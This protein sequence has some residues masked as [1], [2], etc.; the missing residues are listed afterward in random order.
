MFAVRS[1]LLCR[2]AKISRWC[3]LVT[4]SA[5]AESTSR[6]SSSSTQTSNM[7]LQPNTTRS[8]STEGEHLRDVL[9][10]SMQQHAVA[11]PDTG[12]VQNGMIEK[13]ALRTLEAKWDLETYQRLHP[14][15]QCNLR[16]KQQRLELIMAQLPKMVNYLKDSRPQ[17]WWQ[18][19]E[20]MELRRT[21]AKEALTELADRMTKQNS[22]MVRLKD[23][24]RDAFFELEIHL[25]FNPAKTGR[26]CTLVNI[27]DDLAAVD[28][29]LLDAFEEDCLNFRTQQRSYNL[30]SFTSEDMQAQK[31]NDLVKALAEMKYRRAKMQQ[32][33]QTTSQK[34][35]LE[36]L[37]AEIKDLVEE[38]SLL[39]VPFDGEEFVFAKDKGVDVAW[40]DPDERNSDGES[41]Q[42]EPDSEVA[43]ATKTSI[44]DAKDE[45]L[46]PS[47]NVKNAPCEHSYAPRFCGSSFRRKTGAS[48][49]QTSPQDSSSSFEQARVKS[50]LNAWRARC[51]RSRQ[52]LPEEARE[53]L[54]QGQP[55]KDDC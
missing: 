13:L 31:T 6:L 46:E 28:D 47:V 41:A 52:D 8:V 49:D 33:E 11:G 34:Q 12:H 55:H 17:N 30:A 35:E 22:E 44:A 48:V 5:V 3:W 2:V 39:G 20:T 18:S 4:L 36:R 38:L 29:D 25:D 50:R 21:L 54:K 16:A 15:A 23:A 51:E 1:L 24:L 19:L 42:G 43:T 37:N 32:N 9:A 14:D 40:E 53:A 7:S 27:S 10:Q 45:E 26:S